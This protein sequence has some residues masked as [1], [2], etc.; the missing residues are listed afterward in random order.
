R[1]MSPEVIQGGSYS[2]KSD[3]WAFG[4][5]CWEVLTCCKTPYLSILQD[6]KVSEYVCGGGRLKRED[7]VAGCPQESWE[8][9]ESCWSELPNHR[10]TFSA[11]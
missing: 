2:E 1:Y 10:P 3:V 4:V 7:I 6:D 9:I 8:L 5:T 11:I